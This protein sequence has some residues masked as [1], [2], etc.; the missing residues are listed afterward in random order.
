MRLLGRI[1]AKSDDNKDFKK[2]KKKE[3]KTH[4]YAYLNKP[5]EFIYDTRQ[6]HLPAA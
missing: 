3:K 6:A 5:K 1:K 4:T 2:K